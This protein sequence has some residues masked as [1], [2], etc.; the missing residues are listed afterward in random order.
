MHHPRLWAVTPFS[1]T[2]C[3][4]PITNQSIVTTVIRSCRVMSTI[5]KIP[6]IRCFESDLLH[7][8]KLRKTG[9]Y[10]YQR[11]RISYHNVLHSFPDYIFRPQI[12]LWPAT[13]LTQIPIVIPRRACHH[14]PFLP[15]DHKIGMPCFFR[16]R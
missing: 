13:T 4:P 10:L 8:L 2:Q 11:I 5:F 1:G 15:T 3:A 7:Q 16:I 6:G 14:T 12:S 9:R